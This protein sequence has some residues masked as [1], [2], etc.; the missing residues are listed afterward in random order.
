MKTSL[1]APLASVALVTSVSL[2]LLADT[3]QFIISGDPVA[4]AS[5]DSHA[6]E[7]AGIALATGMLSSPTD[8][9]WIEARYRTRHESDGIALRSDKV[10]GFTIVVR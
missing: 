6:A 2:T 5:A 1:L 10:L 3:Y 9:S 8:P 4:A 7:S